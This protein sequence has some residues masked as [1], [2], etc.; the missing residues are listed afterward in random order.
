MG[1]D[2]NLVSAI[3]EL[4]TPTDSTSTNHFL[5]LASYNHRYIP[6]LA[7]IAAPLYHLTNNGVAFEWSQ[8]CQAGLTV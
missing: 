3:R 4:A 1:P 5:G 8:V 6:C 7:D 2:P